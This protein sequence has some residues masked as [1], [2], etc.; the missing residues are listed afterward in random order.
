MFEFIETYHLT[1]IVIGAR[2]NNFFYSFKINTL[3]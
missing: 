1:G 3:C 2:T